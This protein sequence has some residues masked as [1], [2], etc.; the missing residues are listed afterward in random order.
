MKLSFKPIC[1]YG[2]TL[3]STLSLGC[4]LT[5][6]TPVS[7][8]ASNPK[9]NDISIQT[10]TVIEDTRLLNQIPI[11]TASN[12]TENLASEELDP[13]IPPIIVKH[14]EHVEKWIK[15]FTEKSKSRFE[16]YLSRGAI[17]KNVVQ[18][19]LKENEVPPEIY[20]LA[21]IE[22]GY[23]TKAYSSASAVGVWQF[24]KGTGR[25][26]GLESNYYL[27]E[28]RDPIRATEAAAKYLKDLYRAFQ[29]W[30]LAMAAYNAGEYRVLS[31]IIRGKSRD[32]WYLVEKKLL[33]RET[34]NYVPKFFASVLIGSNPEKYGLT[35]DYSA[36]EEFPS[37]KA[38]EVPT[39]I[40]L[41]T[42]SNVTS[43]PYNTLKKANAHLKRGMT[44]PGHKVY[45]I[46]I[47]E[48]FE[49][50]FEEKKPLL[51]KYKAKGIKKSY[52]ANSNRNY[53]KVRKGDTLSSIAMRYKISVRHLKRLNNL[54]SSRIYANQKLRVAAKGYHKSRGNSPTGPSHLVRK[55]ETLSTIA[56]KYR[57]TIKAFKLANNLRGNRIYVGQKLSIPQV[58]KTSNQKIYKVRRGD[59]LDQIS[60]KYKIT[61]K[62]IMTSNNM[63]S[64]RIYPGMKLIIPQ[65][66]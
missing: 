15:Y 16:R 36:V 32:Y 14:N 22:S 13:D 63:N 19:I 60:K 4:A 41:K 46:W 20:Y 28:R 10:E 62:K 57:K 51:A 35:P 50:N 2:L 1:S 18:E 65:N 34:R 5:P 48:E 12:E 11:D 33:P 21:M 30:E 26:Y 45:E 29:S 64:T 23:N 38:V 66:T 40:R 42:L 56:R 52:Y 9:A 43:I 31:A 6:S 8:V 37:V 27:D 59:T 7:E 3:I 39:P 54:R 44:P 55:G 17:Y 49:K 61:I 53:H 47:P 58:K 24:I 25:R